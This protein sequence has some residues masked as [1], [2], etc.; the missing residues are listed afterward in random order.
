MVH[1]IPGKFEL[2]LLVVLLFALPWIGIHFINTFFHGWAKR[3][4]KGDVISLPKVS[5]AIIVSALFVLMFFIVGLILKFQ[6][7]WFFG[8]T[9]GG[10]FE[11][12][13]L[14]AVAWLAGYLVP[15]AP[16]GLGVRRP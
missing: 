10:V 3:L 8:V 4:T 15:G 6:A 16:G 13:C 14:F 1:F 11:L 9:E 12:T 2:I 5:T 7:Q